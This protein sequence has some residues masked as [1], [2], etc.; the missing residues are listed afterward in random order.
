MEQACGCRIDEPDEISVLRI[1]ALRR[2]KAAVFR[3]F[4]N[5]FEY[6]GFLGAGGKEHNI[7]CTIYGRKLES[8]PPGLEFFNPILANH[9]FGFVQRVGI[10]KSEAVCPSGPIPSSIRSKIGNLPAFKLKKPVNACL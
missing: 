3:P 9:L 4:E 7:F 6:L 10:G 2:Q 8:E 1:D 5:L